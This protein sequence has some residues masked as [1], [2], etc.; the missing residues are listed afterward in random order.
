MNW[1]CARSRG[2]D[3][4]LCKWSEIRPKK[5]IVCFRF[6]TD[7]IKTCA[8]QIYLMDFQGIHKLR[9]DLPTVIKVTLL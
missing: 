3:I 5:N 6:L 4:K 8:T 2:Q 7:P 1:F 9:D